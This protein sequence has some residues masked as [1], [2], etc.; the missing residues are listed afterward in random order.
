MR[1]FAVL[2]LVPLMAMPAY[3]M[4]AP[5]DGGTLDVDLTTEP[6]RI[7]PGEEARLNIDFINPV[8]QQTQIHIDYF[9]TVLEDGREVFG[10]TNRIHTSEGTVS[11]PIQ[12]QRDGQYEVK[13]DVDGI[14]FNPIPMETAY[15]V[16][17]VGDAAA[18]TAQPPDGNDNDN[19]CLIATAAFGS[20]MSD[21]VQMLREIRD[22]S[23]LATQSGAA[24]MAG[25]NQVY[26]S[27]SPTVADWERQSP[28][29][30]EAVKA[31][32]TP[33]IA[34]LSVLNHVNMDTEAEVLGYGI[35]IIALNLGMY[36]CLPLVGVLKLHQSRKR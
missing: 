5:T 19:G 13:V 8:T 24:F 14:L 25:F 26:Y 10:P 3:G 27:F 35:G 2:M 23:L 22:N 16:L 20:E 28:V 29:F 31:G 33:L 15:F 4:I 36:V 17:P 7:N 11:I 34:S 1:F 6:E 21:E 9:V 18:D 32:I 12:F 30:R